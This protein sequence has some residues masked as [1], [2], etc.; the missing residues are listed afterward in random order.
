MLMVILVTHFSWKMYFYGIEYNVFIYLY[1]VHR[2]TK[3]NSLTCSPFIEDVV[4]ILNR[5]HTIIFN[6]GYY[7][8]Q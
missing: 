6:C 4:A 5:Q 3:D 1:I 7:A 2:L 8:I